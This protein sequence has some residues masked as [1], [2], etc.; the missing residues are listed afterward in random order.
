ME[1]AIHKE[2]LVILNAHLLP[3]E[4]YQTQEWKGEIETFNIKLQTSARLSH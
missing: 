4:A 1:E 2:Y 3:D